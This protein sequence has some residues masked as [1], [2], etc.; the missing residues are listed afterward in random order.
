MNLITQILKPVSWI[1]K[2]SNP[3]NDAMKCIELL[4]LVCNG[5]VI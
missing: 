5:R 1:L 3:M 2:M 4:L